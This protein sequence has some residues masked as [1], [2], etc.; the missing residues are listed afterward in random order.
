MTHI[1]RWPAR[2]YWTFAGLVLP[3]V[4][5]LLLLLATIS[6]PFHLPGAV[7]LVTGLNWLLLWKAAALAWPSGEGRRGR[8]AWGL[9]VAAAMSFLAAVAE[10][11]IY[12]NVACPDAGC[13]S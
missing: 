10:V 6:L 11:V 2:G 13:F 9:A 5:P 7:V 1:S 12:L 3:L 8:V 4:N